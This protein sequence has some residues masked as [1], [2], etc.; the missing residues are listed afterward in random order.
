MYVAMRRYTVTRPE[1]VDE[2]V[3]RV[4]AEPAATS[5]AA[6]SPTEWAVTE[7][8]FAPLVSRTPGFEAYYLV[9]AG[10]G[11]L[12][13]I[14]LFADRAGAE[15]STREAAAWVSGHPAG[16]VHGSPEVLTG[17]VVGYQ[18]RPQLPRA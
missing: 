7:W 13:S 2:F 10:A 3:R 15:A 17:E 18:T 14:S 12:V 9:D 1:A 6:T 16:L 8:G 4:M 11:V 5:A